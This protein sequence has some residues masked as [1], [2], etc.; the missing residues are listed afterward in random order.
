MSVL[1]PAKP[2]GVEINRPPCPKCGTAMFIVRIYPDEKPDYDLRTFECPDCNYEEIR[3]V[4]F[5]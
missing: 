2:R 5:R 1:S 4:K 3:C